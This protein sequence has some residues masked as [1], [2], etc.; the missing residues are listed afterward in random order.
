MAAN[1]TPQREQVICQMSSRVA[2]LI[3]IT[4]IGVCNLDIRLTPARLSSRRQREHEVTDKRT[5][6][7]TR[8]SFAKILMINYSQSHENSVKPRIAR[9]GRRVCPGL[10]VSTVSCI[11]IH[12]HK[13]YAHICSRATGRRRPG[14]SGGA[15]VPSA[16]GLYAESLSARICR[17]HFSVGHKSQRTAAKQKAQ[18][19][20][21]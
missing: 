10:T 4:A 20:A 13:C 15:G 5:E 14:R 2:R 1:A 16:P 21:R 17:K 3:M 18:V 11:S 6:W 8:Y 7:C 9:G 19:E 12:S